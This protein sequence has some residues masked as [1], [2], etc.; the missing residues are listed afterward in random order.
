MIFGLVIGSQAN[1][2]RNNICNTTRGILSLR[3]GYSL[4][5]D[6]RVEKLRQLLTREAD[7]IR[8]LA[9]QVVLSFTV[10]AV[11][12]LFGIGPIQTLS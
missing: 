2:E 12:P 10:L 6:K 11:L 3:G 1:P 8:L 5:V 4:P 9:S 7:N